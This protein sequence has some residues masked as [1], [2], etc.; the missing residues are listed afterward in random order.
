MH[1][2]RQDMHFCKLI[3]S[4]GKSMKGDWYSVNEGGFYIKFLV[5]QKR[6]SNNKE[7]NT[8]IAS[9][10]A[11]AMKKKKKSKATDNSNSENVPESFNFEHLKIGADSN[12]EWEQ[13]FKERLSQPNLFAK[14]TL[15]KNWLNYIN[16]INKSNLKGEKSNIRWLYY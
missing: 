11:K 10:M 2:P 12:Y 8:L 4:E 6:L 5:T 3:Q 13:S 16:K 14:S 15:N 1:T 7:L 9:A